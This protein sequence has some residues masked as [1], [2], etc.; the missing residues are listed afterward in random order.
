MGYA[1]FQFE[2]AGNFR[3]LIGKARGVHIQADADDGEI[4][5]CLDE[6]AGDLAGADPDIVGPLDA[7]GRAEGLDRFGDRE[8]GGKSEAR[9]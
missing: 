3:H 2:R 9:P 7:G 8:A 4:R 6:D 5:A 1:G